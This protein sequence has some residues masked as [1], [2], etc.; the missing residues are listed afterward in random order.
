MDDHINRISQAEILI[1]Y[2]NRCREN[3]AALYNAAFYEYFTKGKTTGNVDGIDGKPEFIS[4][5]IM[6]YDQFNT[7]RLQAI[8]FNDGEGRETGV[9]RHFNVPRRR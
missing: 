4:L 3:T 2:L 5:D 7:L 6:K 9:S 1:C 8:L